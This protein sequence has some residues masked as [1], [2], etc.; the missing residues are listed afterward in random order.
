MKKYLLILGIV[1][2]IYLIGLCVRIAVNQPLM[3]QGWVQHT[4]FVYRELQETGNGLSRAES[5]ERG[6]IIS[7]RPEY[8]ERYRQARELTRRHLKRVTEL[9][10]DNP[11]QQDNILV[12]QNAIEK[13]FQEID[14]KIEVFDTQGREAATVMLVKGHGQVTIDLARRIILTMED[15]EDVLLTRRQRDSTRLFWHLA[16]VVMAML[17]KEMTWTYLLF[18][19]TGRHPDPNTIGSPAGTTR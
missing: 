1:L 4:Q 6:Y 18:S 11:D 19:T 16:F 8:I 17:V 15:A 2:D 3:P 13:R 14:Q 7:G 12:L 9:T 10:R 5:N